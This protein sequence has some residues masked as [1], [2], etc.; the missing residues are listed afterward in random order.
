MNNYIE[1]FNPDLGIIDHTGTLE[2]FIDLLGILRLKD[3]IDS[4]NTISPTCFKAQEG[5]VFVA[6]IL[7]IKNY[8]ISFNE[9]PLTAK[10]TCLRNYVICMMIVALKE[11]VIA[12]QKQPLQI[13]GIPFLEPFADVFYNQLQLFKSI[14]NVGSELGIYIPDELRDEKKAWGKS[15][16]REI[17]QWGSGLSEKSKR[18]HYTNL[19]MKGKM[20]HSRE[21]PFTKQDLELK[22]L[23]D[24]SLVLIASI[25]D[26]DGNRKD[27]RKQISSKFDNLRKSYT[28]LSRHLKD[29][30]NIQYTTVRYGTHWLVCKNNHYEKISST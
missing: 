23:V 3:E 8:I 22:Y 27:L 19:R 12:G 29:N 24:Y 15:I 16:L 10:Q 13:V 20:L 2:I 26:S 1:I 4:R 14:K 9:I 17:K 25:V 21:N 18:E 7:A 5:Q 6:L 30:P 11:G 28:A